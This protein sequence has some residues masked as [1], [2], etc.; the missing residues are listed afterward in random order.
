MKKRQ[1]VRK[2]RAES[3]P[4]ATISQTLL[5]VLRH[6]VFHNG[7]FKLLALV[8][9]LVLWAGLIS[10][11]ESLTRD[12][13][14][15][16]VS[17]NVTGTE[18]M[19]R[20]GYIITS[21]LSEL[22]SSVSAVAAVPQTQYEAV[23]AS[24]YNI[25]VDCSKVSGVGEQELKLQSTNSSTYGR[26]TSLTPSSITVEVEDY[27]TRYRI[28]V[29]VTVS[30]ETPA[31]WYM[32]TPS[33][34]PPLVVV[35]GPKSLVNSIS[36]GRVFVSTDEVD[37]V[38]GTMILTGS[39][40]LYNRSGEEITSSLLQITYENVPVDS[41]V[42]EA[43]ILPTR[44]FEVTGI[45]GVLNEVADGYVVDA[46][47]VSP[48]NITVAARQ[49]VLDQMN[50]LALS[51]RYVDVK[52]LKET[53]SFQLKVSKPSDDAVL[54]NDTITVTVDIVPEGD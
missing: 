9:S 21:D 54:S 8:I 30:G 24:V 20:N 40:S 44:T 5:Q 53:T 27:V 22:L 18:T 42:L 33:V 25:R 15:N 31:G 3:T 29:S 50:E 13:V 11:D 38:E 17:V 12:K 23:E 46:I 48:E 34:D 14:F 37:W 7:G 49:E 28:P 52:G 51:D 19:K 32:A 45:I 16:N 35:S 2:E 47:H 10:Q 26:V 1:P 43:T 6:L 41:V 36:R 4:R 39:L